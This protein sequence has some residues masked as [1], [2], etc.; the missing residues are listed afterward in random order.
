MSGN[1]FGM[2]K[3]EAEAALL[4]LAASTNMDV[5]I[6][7][8]PLVY[9]PRVKANFLSM[10]R[11]LERGIPLP[12]GA[13]TENRRS[14]IG[15]DNLVDLILT[16]LDH[17][18]AANQ[19]FLAS[20]G[21]DLSTA[22]LLRRAAEALGVKARLVPVPVP[23]LVASAALLGRRDLVQRLLHSLRVDISKASRLLGWS[24]PFTVDD[25]LRRAS[26][27]VRSRGVGRLTRVT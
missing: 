3:A 12:L 4:D 24:P 6:I 19:V 16:C 9:G 23:I 10:I 11:C 15:L 22:G 8:P 17:P 25:E 7:R 1:L 14:L 18:A 20:D 5:V 21:E 26:H 27:I 13:V 2:S